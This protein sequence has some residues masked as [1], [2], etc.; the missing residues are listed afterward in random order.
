ML[1]AGSPHSRVSRAA[2]P[3]GSRGFLQLRVAPLCL[4]SWPRLPSPRPVFTRPPFLHLSGRLSCSYQ[5]TCLWKRAT[6]IQE[7]LVSYPQLRSPVSQQG[8]TLSSGRARMCRG[9]TPTTPRLCESGGGSFMARGGPDEGLGKPHQLGHGICSRDGWQVLALAICH[10]GPERPRSAGG[11]GDRCEPI[12]M[13]IAR[14]AS[15][16]VPER[17]LCFGRH[18]PGTLSRDSGR[19]Q[20]RSDNAFTFRPRR[21]PHSAR[22][23]LCTA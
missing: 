11:W 4:G 2:A 3:E 1:E 22:P 8:G 13:Q 15:P 12:S 17:S 18:P 14:G 19:Y 23:L 7:S 20:T 9:H 21:H 6:P 16:R 5:D 10:Q